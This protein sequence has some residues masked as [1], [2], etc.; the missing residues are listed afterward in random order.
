M[1]KRTCCDPSTVCD[2]GFFR[3]LADPGRLAILARLAMDCRPQTVGDVASCCPTDYSVVSRHLA[4]LRDAGL[5]AAEKRGREVLYTVRYD[6]VVRTL[7]ALADA[8]ETCAA[9]GGCDA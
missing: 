8:I 6:N 9:Q 4:A 3:S 1:A 7:R 2:P 5:L